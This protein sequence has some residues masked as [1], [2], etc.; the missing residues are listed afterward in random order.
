MTAQSWEGGAAIGSGRASFTTNTTYNGYSR[1]E[2]IVI[3]GTAN[4][5]ARS[6]ANSSTTSSAY[7]G[8]AIGAGHCARVG[9]I[10]ISGGTV[11][12]TMSDYFAPGIGSGK[13]RSTCGN[14]TINGG[15]VEA[16][17]GQKAAGIG[18]GYGAY[19]LVSTCGTITIT[20]GVTQVKAT[21]GYQGK[22]S[23]GAGGYNNNAN[24]VSCG[25]VTIGGS[26]GQISTSPY[27]YTPGQ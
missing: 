4:V 2:G 10:T 23:I 26:T 27:T 20:T 22:H 7:A 24:Q 21:M 1:C 18:T 15:T 8:A 11:T 25:T 9:N 17:G 14:I 16:T 5:T 3:E 12:A 19:G 6:T 13:T